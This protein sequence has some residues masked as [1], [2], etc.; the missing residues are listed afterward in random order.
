MLCISLLTIDVN[1]GVEGME[2]GN[3][4]TASV[5]ITGGPNYFLQ[6][7][8]YI[9]GSHRVNLQAADIVGNIEDSETD[10]TDW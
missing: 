4:C 1:A 3:E 9:V 5:V 7:L 2:E 10:F 8:L 6:H